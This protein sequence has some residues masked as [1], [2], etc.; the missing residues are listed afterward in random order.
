[1]TTTSYP[2]VGTN[3]FTEAEWAEYFDGED[4]I[5]NDYAGTGLAL[6]RVAGTDT[7]RYAPGKVRVGGY[8]LEVTA[9]HDLTVGT[10]AATYY[11]WACYDPA[12]NV[13]GGGGAASADGP[14]TLGVSS[15]LPSTA[16][17][18]QYVLLD[19][20]VRSASQALTAAALTPLRRWVG[21]AVEWDGGLTPESV[22]SDYP[23]GSLRY[24]RTRNQMLVRTMN[25]A[26]SAMEWR[27]LGTDLYAYKT[28]TESVT[29]STTLQDDDTLQLTLPV[30]FWRVSALL[31]VTGAAAGDI[32]IAWAFTGTAT[33]TFG[34][35][36]CLGP[37]PGTTD[38]ANS[39]MFMRAAGQTVQVAYGTDGTG[40]TAIWE[41]LTLEVTAEG[42]LKLQWAQNTSSGT[43]TVMQIGSRLI[44][45]R[46]G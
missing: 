13:A 5:V 25:Q 2:A 11:T 12:L 33:A 18:K 36:T 23:R 19:K 35:R 44:A 42:V 43:A 29:S 45:R 22:E 46:I 9:N 31:A 10:A 37:A 3:G 39:S 14:C 1:M 20:I 34:A 24:D 41:D 8:I 28:V 7:A 15:G 4:G 17:G 16:G 32:K 26:G 6:T 27:S 38:T 40:T 30:G 21:T